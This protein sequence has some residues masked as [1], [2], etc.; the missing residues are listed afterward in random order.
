MCVSL[1]KPRAALELFNFLIVFPGNQLA[2]SF[3]FLRWGCGCQGFGADLSGG[4]RGAVELPG[5]PGAYAAAGKTFAGG[6][7]GAVSKWVARFL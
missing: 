2:R 7:K 4:G 6:W 3:C 5:R 1:Q